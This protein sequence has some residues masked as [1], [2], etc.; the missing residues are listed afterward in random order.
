MFLI[1]IILFLFAICAPTTTP[2]ILVLGEKAPRLIETISE[3]KNEISHLLNELKR[4]MIA[5]IDLR[6]RTNY[7]EYPHTL[8]RNHA[9]NTSQVNERLASTTTLNT[10]PVHPVKTIHNTTQWR[11]KRWA[12]WAAARGPGDLG[13]PVIVDVRLR[14]ESTP[15]YWSVGCS[16]ANKKLGCLARTGR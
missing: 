6:I 12:D 8:T 4:E 14:I 5:E 16:K 7:S 11:V 2:I 10:T 9:T 1:A 13:G 3:L 15:R